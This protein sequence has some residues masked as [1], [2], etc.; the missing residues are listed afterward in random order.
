MK[1][2]SPF[3][4][5][6]SPLTWTKS[7]IEMLTAP[8]ASSSLPFSV[9]IS[10]GSV[11]PLTFDQS[12]AAG[13]TAPPEAWLILTFRSGTVRLNAPGDAGERGVVEL[14]VDGGPAA[15]VGRAARLRGCRGLRLATCSVPESSVNPGRP[16]CRRRR[17]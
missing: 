2:S 11:A 7:A 16:G 1:M 12:S 15:R 3:S 5:A 6:N 13:G 4:K 10:P 8:V 14:D 9:A 17:W